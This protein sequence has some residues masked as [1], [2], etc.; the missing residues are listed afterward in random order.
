VA[1]AKTGAERQAA[2][3]ARQAEQQATEVRGIFAHPDDHQAVKD[4]AAKINRRRAR[5]VKKA[6]P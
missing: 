5:S 4:E 6:A 2:F 3:R 1:P